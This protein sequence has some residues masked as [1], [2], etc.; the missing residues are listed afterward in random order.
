MSKG[1][2]GWGKSTRI[3]LSLPAISVTIVCCFCSPAAGAGGGASDKLHNNVYTSGGLTPPSPILKPSIVMT[4]PPP[5]S[6][7]PPAGSDGSVGG[8]LT[9][10]LRWGRRKWGQYHNTTQTSQS[11]SWRENWPIP[12]N[13]GLSL[14]GVGAASET[15]GHSGFPPIDLSATY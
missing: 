7:V 5:D 6:P 14:A 15:K 11:R 8:W 2:L 4:P 3:W 13:I 9:K 12:G 1:A 10:C